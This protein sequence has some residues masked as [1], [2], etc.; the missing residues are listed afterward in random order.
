MRPLTMILIA[1]ALGCRSGEKPSADDP[2]GGGG[3]DTG[4]EQTDDTGGGGSSTADADADGY[5]AAVDCDDAD[6]SVHPGAEEVCDGIDNNCDGDVD[7]GLTDVWY[8]DADGDGYGDGASPVR[9]CDQPVDAVED[10]ADCDDT[11]PTVYPGAEEVCD[12]LDNDCDGEIDGESATDMT[13]WFP[14]SDGDGF[15]LDTEPQLDCN[16]PSGFVDGTVLGDCDDD[17]AS[18]YPGGTE[19]CDDV[20]NDC[21]GLV[22]DE[23]TDADL[24]FRDADAD[25]YGDPDVSL[26]ACNKPGSY[27]ENDEDCDDTDAMIYPAAT[28]VCNGEDDDCNGTIDDGFEFESYYRDADGDGHGFGLDM[29]VH[30]T[31]PAG[32]VT[33]ND[34]CDDDEYWAN[35]E[36]AELCGDDIDN[37]CDGEVDE[38][39]DSYPFYPD[40]DGDGYGHDTEPVYDCA[41]PAGHVLSNTDCDDADAT[42]NPGEVESCNGI[43]DDCNGGVDDGLPEYIWFMDADDDGYGV[44][45]PTTIACAEPPGYA[46]VDTDCD[47]DERTTHPGAYEMCD[48]ED[49]D[50]NGLIDDDCGSSRILSAYEG[51]TCDGAAVSQREIGDYIDV[52]YNSSGTWNDATAMGF[53]I[54]DGEG[55]YYEAC[56]YGSPWQQVTVE[57]VQGSATYNHTGNYS[58]RAWSWTTDCSDVVEDDGATGVIHEWSVASVVITKTEIWEDDGRVSRVWFDIENTGTTEIDNLR[59]MFGVDPDHDYAPHSSFHTLNDTR[60]AGDYAESVGPTS[61]W[62]LAFGACDLDNDDLG[63]TAWSTDADAV[64]V[65]D[66][67]ASGDRTMHWRHTEDSVAAGGTASF[68]F[69]VTVG[70]TPEEAVEAYEEAQPILCTDG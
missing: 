19:V 64:F 55:T 44:P 5:N 68:G 20:D 15:G 34:D 9:A 66:G 69:L 48:G 17:D 50:C 12:G 47:D 8:T 59:V 37:D 53:R 33:S 49:D 67:A 63:H 40:S 54:G 58:S 57:Y 22:D 36:V 14:D 32:Y 70:Q 35:P 16:A 31:R 52:S 26:L 30:C 2:S 11:Q 4:A 6:A 60:D 41:P 45:E 62:T 18:A 28:E 24:W 21:D 42:V 27:V 61:E 38:D 13:E 43:D 51:L 3:G 65:D 7:E 39:F 25:S 46:P 23:A 10:F 1:A 56:Y 29:V